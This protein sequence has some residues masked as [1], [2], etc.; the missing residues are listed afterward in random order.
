M[1]EAKLGYSF[2]VKGLLVEALT[3]PSQQELGAKY[4]Y[5]VSGEHKTI[6]LVLHIV[7]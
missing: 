4:C 6:L 5:E 3:H 7:S 1:L 2:S